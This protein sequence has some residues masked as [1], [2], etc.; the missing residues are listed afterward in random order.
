MRAGPSLQLRTLPSRVISALQQSSCAA[1][2]GAQA[3]LSFPGAEA[4]LASQEPPS[5][6]SQCEQE[7][8]K[9]SFW[10]GKFFVSRSETHC[11]HPVSVYGKST[12][13]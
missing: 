4:A 2:G 7:S 13:G 3:M 12:F 8:T 9:I 6:A 5:P 11:L 1:G 10:Q